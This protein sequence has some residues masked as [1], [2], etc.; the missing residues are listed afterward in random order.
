MTKR[1]HH[2]GAPEHPNRHGIATREKDNKG[3]IKKIA[4]K[5]GGIGYSTFN[6]AVRIVCV[7]FITA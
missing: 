4:F 3:R 5:M 1:D 6:K 7:L 2:N